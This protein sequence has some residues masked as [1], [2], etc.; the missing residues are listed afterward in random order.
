M[1]SGKRNFSCKNL[2]S[3]LSTAESNVT[4]SKISGVLVNSAHIA[5]LAYC[6]SHSGLDSVNCGLMC[7]CNYFFFAC[8]S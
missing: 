7:R 2:P 4:V 5:T 3:D 8:A 6:E 1:G